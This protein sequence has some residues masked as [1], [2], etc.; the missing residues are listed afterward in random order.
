MVYREYISHSW[1]DFPE[2]LIYLCQITILAWR[3]V[4]RI[5]KEMKSAKSPVGVFKVQRKNVLH[6]F[7][8]MPSRYVCQFSQYFIWT[9]F[10]RYEINFLLRLV[11]NKDHKQ[12]FHVRYHW[13]SINNVMWSPVHESAVKH[14]RLNVYPILFLV[15]TATNVKRK[16]FSATVETR[17]KKD[18]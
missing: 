2:F 9:F 14:E 13:W 3:I 6:V 16:V 10:L 7:F 1:L 12:R 5:R 17:Q 11:K 8:I 18:W 4:C 15:A